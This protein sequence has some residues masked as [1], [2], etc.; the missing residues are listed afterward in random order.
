LLPFAVGQVSVV[1]SAAR[2]RCSSAYGPTLF[3]RALNR[4]C[5]SHCYRCPARPGE[6]T[7]YQVHG[8]TALAQ[9]ELR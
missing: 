4:C 6:G 7:Q 2:H 5:W 1:G 3:K 8:T 9:I